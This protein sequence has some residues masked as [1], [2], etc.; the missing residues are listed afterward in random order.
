VIAYVAVRD[1]VFSK[2]ALVV[3]AGTR[4]RWTWRGESIHN[5]AVVKGPQKF[6]SGT[7]T[8]GRYTH[9]VTRPGTYKILC[10]IHA[11]DMKMTL[12]VK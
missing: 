4:V 3:E 10:T 12:T 6:R 5:V 7:K 1:D 2:T 11:P 9:K 8:E